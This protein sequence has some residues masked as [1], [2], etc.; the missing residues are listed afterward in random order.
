MARRD[1]Q[2]RLGTLLF[3][4]YAVTAFFALS[5]FAV[6]GMDGRQ[7]ANLHTR[8][9]ALYFTVATMATVGYGDVYAA[10]QVARALVTVQMGFDLVIIAAL[11]GAYRQSFTR[12][13]GHA[14]GW[15]S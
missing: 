6:A 11:V 8:T 9:D 3:L 10:G 13:S 4:I 12:R 5:C 14:D 1:R 2:A 15:S 7:F